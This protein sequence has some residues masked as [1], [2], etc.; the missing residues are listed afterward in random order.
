MT[1]ATYNKYLY[2]FVARFSLIQ[3][4]ILSLLFDD[5]AVTESL[6]VGGSFLY[7]NPSTPK[8]R[9]DA[10][11]H[12]DPNTGKVVYDM[13]KVHETFIE[14]WNIMLAGFYVE[15]ESFIMPIFTEI[16]TGYGW[17][18]AGLFELFPD[19]MHEKADSEVSESEQAYLDMAW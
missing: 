7:N 12:I 5:L 6:M 8:E 4:Q 14:D 19:Y 10:G 1:I 15:F 3:S 11:Y 17:Y 9:E 16:G 2:R 13:V 18:E